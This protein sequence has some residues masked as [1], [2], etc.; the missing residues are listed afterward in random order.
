MSPQHIMQEHGHSHICVFVP[1]WHHTIHTLNL[2]CSS[3]SC[4][5]PRQVPAAE[6]VEAFGRLLSGCLA[7]PP[8]APSAPLPRLVVAF[9]T[10]QL[11]VGVYGGGG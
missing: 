6:R 8:A 2:L 7:D 10:R 3:L 5:T 1:S 9:V 4:F 11:P